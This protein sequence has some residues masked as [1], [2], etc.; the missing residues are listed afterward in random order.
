MVSSAPTIRRRGSQ[1]GASG[2]Q[3]CPLRHVEK[4]SHHLTPCT[5]VR[6]AQGRGAD[7]PQVLQELDE[8]RTYRYAVVRLR[9]TRSERATADEPTDNA[10]CFAPRFCT[11][12]PQCFQLD[13][14]RAK[15][16]TFANL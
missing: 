8:E 6:K 2:T 3:D 10:L 14:F 12:K 13:D 4:D 11:E 16:L 9:M 1:C 15:F 7:S 5:Y